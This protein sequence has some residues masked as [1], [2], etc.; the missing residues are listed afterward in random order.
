MRTSRIGEVVA[1][2]AVVSGVVAAGAVYANNLGEGPERVQVADLAS[3]TSDQA[4]TVAERATEKVVAPVPSTPVPAKV[5]AVDTVQKFVATPKP[6]KAVCSAR[7][8]A[9]ALTVD[10]LVHALGAPGG[11]VR[12]EAAEST[13][14]ARPA[15][16]NGCTKNV[17]LFMGENYAFEG[18]LPYGSWV[19]DASLSG[20]RKSVALL[21]DGASV[22]VAPQLLDGNCGGVAEVEVRTR[23]EDSELGLSGP[24]P[25]TKVTAKRVPDGEC[26]IPAQSTFTTGADGTF[27]GSLGY[28]DWMF[29]MGTGDQRISEFVVVGR[30]T[31]EIELTRTVDVLG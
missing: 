25:G 7:K 31:D 9:V 18:R 13:I 19:L 26:A 17:K 3:A 20:A 14:V 5:P 2:V 30:D 23:T 16:G 22:A 12:S 8:G 6:A 10:A 15:K 28:G 4:S 27:V 11:T 24:L 1:A 21:V 29:S